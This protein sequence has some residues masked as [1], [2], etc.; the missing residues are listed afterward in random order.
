MALFFLTEPKDLTIYFRC[1]HYFINSVTVIDNQIKCLFYAQINSSIGIERNHCHGQC[2][3]LLILLINARVLSHII[4][5]VLSP[6]HWKLPALTRGSSMSLWMSWLVIYHGAP[7]IVLS[8]I[9]WYLWNISMLE[10]LIL[11][12]IQNCTARLASHF[13]EFPNTELSKIN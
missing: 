3:L 8:V 10:L 6:F 11:H 5:I 7:V 4:P 9:D 1:M 12:E 13:F 2:R